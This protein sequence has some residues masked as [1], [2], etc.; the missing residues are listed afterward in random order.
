MSAPNGSR[1]YFP[2]SSDD[3]WIDLDRLR[4]IIGEIESLGGTRITPVDL[5][6]RLGIKDDELD[7][8]KFT[9][10]VAEASGRPTILPGAAN[11]QEPGR[12]KATRDG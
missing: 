11:P 8:L 4:E 6:N 12:R 5:L 10:R 1:D 7:L 9:R 2:P 3:E